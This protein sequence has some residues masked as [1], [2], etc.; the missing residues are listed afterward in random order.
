M[1]SNSTV[2]DNV[3]SELLAPKPFKKHLISNYSEDS[4]RT[5]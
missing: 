3:S 5:F 1:E 2:A 4:F